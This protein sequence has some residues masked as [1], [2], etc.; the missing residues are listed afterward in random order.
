MT[1]I[2]VDPGHAWNGNRYPPQPSYYEG[3]Q[4][5][6]LA[7]FLKEQLECRG[8]Y[9]ETTRPKLKDFL[10]VAD[11]GK[12]AK[13]FDLVISLHSNAPASVS[14]TKTTGTVIFR[15]VETPEII[16]LADD[17]GKRI[18]KLMNH[19]Y[20]GTITK[21]STNPLRKGKNYNGVLRNAMAAGCKAGLLVEHGFHTNPKDAA[22]LA[23]KDNLKRLAI[24]EAEAIANYYGA[25]DKEG[26]LVISRTLRHGMYGADVELVQKFLQA[27]GYYSG[28]IDASFGPGQGFLNAVKAFQAGNGLDPDGSI[29]PATRAL[30]IDMMINPTEK[31]VEKTVEVEKIVEVEKVVKVEDTTKVNKLQAEVSTLKAKNEDFVQYFRLHNELA[32]GV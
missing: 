3:T 24:A 2:L 26:E 14:D 23:E 32:K 11:R 16:P 18:A 13:G 6:V 1:R 28:T 30:I 15:T 22:F 19:H 4:M 7:N 29:G 8:F 12:M 17:M 10:D 31:V 27:R 25:S 5:W 20:R 9:V 21:L